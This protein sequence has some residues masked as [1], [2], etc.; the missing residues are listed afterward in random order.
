MKGT[1]KSLIL[2]AF[3]G[4]TYFYCVILFWGFFPNVNPITQGL[5][6]C[7]AAS[8]W[9]TPTVYVH[10]LLINT[11]IFIPLAIFLKKVC[12]EPI[13]FYVVISL[14]S[15][16]V[17]QGLLAGFTTHIPALTMELLCLP[18]AYL[19]TNLGRRTHE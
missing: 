14:V 13:W 4:I 5:L 19:L 7:C 6:S 1:L 9:L 17:F 15:G 12:D 16:F 8:N 3:S 2:S 10:D 18:I 11:L